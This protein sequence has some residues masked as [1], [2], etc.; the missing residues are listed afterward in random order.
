M[1][2]TSRIRRKR[3]E[4]LPKI[5]LQ[6]TTNDKPTEKEITEQKYFN[7][8]SLPETNLVAAK[9]AIAF[10]QARKTRTDK[11][12]NLSVVALKFKR[13]YLRQVGVWRLESKIA[14]KIQNPTQA[15][16]E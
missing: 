14:T 10:G 11:T 13:C 8:V 2:A 6:R 4:Y 5:A 1:R 7:V 15:T 3:L 12:K 16:S 9:S